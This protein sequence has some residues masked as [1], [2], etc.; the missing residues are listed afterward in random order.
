[1]RRTAAPVI[2]SIGSVDPTGAAGVTRDLRVYADLGAV[3]VTVVAAVTAQNDR[4]VAGVGPVAPALIIRQL[5]AVW[6]QT[7]P[8]AL[9]I[10][11]LPHA[12]GVKAVRN[13][14]SRLPR[15]PPIVIDPVIAASNGTR[16]VGSRARSEL[17]RLLPLATVVTP[18][19]SEAAELSNMKVTTQGHAQSA[20]RAL[21]RCGAAVLVTGGH[22]IGSTCVDTLAR[23]N[24]VRYFATARVTRTM[25]GAGGILAAA[26]AVYLARGATLERAVE[27]ARLFVRREFRDA[28]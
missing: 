1:L 13:F 3:G 18:N 9:C 2:C 19:S 25:R 17:L 8:D 28:G 24:R 26:I 21:A 4:R 12:A 7:K 23:G 11:L 14:L 20:A 6:E 10:G 27:R 5:E 15:R 22:L 16:F